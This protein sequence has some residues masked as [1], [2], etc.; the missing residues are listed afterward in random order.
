MKFVLKFPSGCYKGFH[1]KPAVQEWLD[2]RWLKRSNCMSDLHLRVP[3]PGKRLKAK[4]ARELAIV[5]ARAIDV[6]P[7]AFDHLCQAEC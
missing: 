1:S 7:E 5:T 6:D 2:L 4:R 3:C